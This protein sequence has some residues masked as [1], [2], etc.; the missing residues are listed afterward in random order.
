MPPC[1]PHLIKKKYIRKFIPDRLKSGDVFVNL[2]LAILNGVP[3]L[4]PQNSL[5]I[6]VVWSGRSEIRESESNSNQQAIDIFDSYV[7]SR[8]IAF[9]SLN[10][11][12]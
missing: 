2:F 12:S 8:Y 1:E 11:D 9:S 10:S 7:P 3:P 6:I 4:S 5:P